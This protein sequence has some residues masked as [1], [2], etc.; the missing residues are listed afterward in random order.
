MSLR[1][2]LESWLQGRWYGEQQPGIVLRGLARLQAGLVRLNRRRAATAWRAPVPVVVVGNLTAGGTGKTPFVAWLAAALKR[3][4]LQ[5]GVVSRGYGRRS[6][7]CLLVEANSDS[8]RVGDEPLLLQ[9]L[10]GCPVAVGA[11]RPQA[12]RLLLSHFSLD[13]IVS[14]DGLQHYPL[15]RDREIAVIDGKRGFGNGR[16]IPAGP[17]REPLDRLDQVHWRVWN[18]Q[19]PEAESGLLM[20]LRTDSA[21]NLMDGRRRPLSDFAPG[22]VRA[23]AGMGAPQRFFDTLAGY[24]IKLIEEAPGDHAR[25]QAEQDDG[26]T[27]LMTD[28]DAVKLGERAAAHWW[29]VPVEAELDDAGA[30]LDELVA[31]CRQW[32]DRD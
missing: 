30:M 22:P 3:R 14:D 21:V 27:V 11:D 5:V 7:D 31:L 13:L 1:R 4:G 15:A 32:Q 17:L 25:W 24:N 2:R 9:R 20:Q 18:G 29:R 23:V 10:T 16:L 26:T 19:R 6:R 8:R 12:C 28:K